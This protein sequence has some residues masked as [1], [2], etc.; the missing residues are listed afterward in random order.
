MLEVVTC[1]YATNANIVSC[2]FHRNRVLAC[3]VT[4][5]PPKD[6]AMRRVLI[7]GF[8]IHTPKIVATSSTTLLCAAEAD[9]RGHLN[10]RVRTSLQNLLR[11]AVSH[12]WR[13]A[14][15]RLLWFPVSAT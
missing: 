14:R 2:N 7:S 11:L 6:S 4:L 10:I 15:L 9:G 13:G 5:R 3:L 1:K 12:L 8:Q